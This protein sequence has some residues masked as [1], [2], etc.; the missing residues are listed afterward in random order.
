MFCKLVAILTLMIDWLNQ[1]KSTPSEDMFLFCRDNEEVEQAALADVIAVR[2]RVC[3]SLAPVVLS[4]HLLQR[5][6]YVFNN[7]PSA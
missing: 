6:R 5:I 1:Q 4:A 3:C 7:L 2:E